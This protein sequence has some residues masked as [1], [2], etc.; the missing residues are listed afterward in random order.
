MLI[1]MK[2]LTCQNKAPL[3]C[4][5]SIRNKKLA[6]GKLC[7]FKHSSFSAVPGNV[8]RFLFC[9]VLPTSNDNLMLKIK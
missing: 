8:F 3:P 9:M 2:P 1:G 6:M 7:G 5:L 4:S